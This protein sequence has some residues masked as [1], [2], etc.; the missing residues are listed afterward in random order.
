MLERIQ[1][2]D[3]LPTLLVRMQ[4]DTVTDEWIKM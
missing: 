3:K 4:I 1:R 2:K